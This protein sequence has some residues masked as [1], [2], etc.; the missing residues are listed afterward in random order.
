MKQP[1][2]LTATCL[3][4]LTLYSCEEK[5]D[6]PAEKVPVTILAGIDT[7]AMDNKW[8]E[9]DAIGVTMYREGEE[10]CLDGSFNIGYVT[11]QEGSHFSPISGDAI[12][13]YPA[14]GA[15]VF[16]KSYYPYKEDLPEDQ[17]YPVEL[18]DQQSLPA[19]DL[20][21]AIHPQG[22]SKSSPVVYMQF[23][24]RLT[25]LIFILQFQ[26]GTSGNYERYDLVVKGMQTSGSYDIVREMLWVDEADTGA[27]HIPLREEEMENEETNKRTG[28]VFP[29]A[30]GSGVTVELTTPG[31]SSYSGSMDRELELEEGYQY[32]IRVVIDNSG[33]PNPTPNPNPN[34]GDPVPLI[35]QVVTIEPWKDGG[36]YTFPAS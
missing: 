21:T 2:L 31:G 17:L 36:D 19:I 16:F 33:D 27:I 24:H 23:Y 22:V 10:T 7:R 15:T 26:D 20:M 34:P 1:A 6:I 8:Q 28:I 25:K 9:G 12:L 3:L 14:D 32:I 29:R 30:A 4:A 35:L 13:Y 18:K 5:A 11:G